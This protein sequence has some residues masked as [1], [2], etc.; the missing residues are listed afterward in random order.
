MTWANYRI[1]RQGQDLFEIVP[2]RIGIG[3]IA[4]AHR[5][6][7][8]RVASHRDGAGK[9]VDDIASGGGTS[10]AGADRDAG[11]AEFPPE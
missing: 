10:A 9:A 5:T 2:K 11:P 8:E 6:G 3:N 1:V 4:A 7:E